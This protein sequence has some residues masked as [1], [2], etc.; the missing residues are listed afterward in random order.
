MTTLRRRG[1]PTALLCLL[2]ITPPAS[3][4]PRFDLAVNLDGFA[5]FMSSRAYIDA[6]A[7]FRRWGRAGAGWEENPALRL[8]PDN[9]PLA[10]ADAV[11]LLRGYPAGVYK[12][13][14]EGAATLTFVGFAQIVPGTL[15]T[16]GGVTTA[17]VRVAPHGG[18]DL[19]TL[20]VRGLDPAKPLRNLHLLVPGYADGTRIFTD[21]FV[22]RVRPFPTLRFMDWQQTNANPLREWSDRPRPT[23][24][25]RTGAQGVP[26]EEIVAL[27][28]VTRRNVWVNVPLHAS[29]DYVTH[30]ATLL[31]DTLH[32]AALIHVEY[33]NEVWNFG[34]EQAKDNLAA[35]KANPALTKPDDF[36]R[37]AQQAADRL[38][39]VARIFRT[40]FGDAA[41]AARVRP[42]VGGFIANTYWAQTQLDWL[43]QH[44]LGLI[45]ELAIAPYFGVEGDIKD[46]DQPGATAD[47]LFAKLNALVEGPLNTWIADHAAL[48][49]AHGVALV[50]YEGGVHLTATN[51]VNEDLKRQMQA[52]PRIADTYRHLLDVWQKHGGGLFTQFG[53]IGP[54]TKFGYWGLLESMD[55]PGS[56]K[57]DFVMSLL[58]PPG[59]ANLDGKVDFADFQIL[60]QNLGQSGRWRE[61]GD[62]NAD[63]KVD[64]A[65]LAIFRDNAHDLTPEQK[66]AFETPANGSRP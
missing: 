59:D 49:K 58:L 39:T 42:V 2:L 5:D 18:E 37:C 17:D 65:D 35:A 51:G 4:G 25:S 44:H 16:E 45:R 46:V 48:A 66:A 22:R 23:R 54:Y 14:Y 13:R 56:I 27:A 60:R 30:F 20:Q 7:L 8:S 41:Y 11:T 57:W 19:L 26:L 50:A 36:G 12:L 34:F 62:L 1:V 38:G 29:D 64:A 21:E 53:H 40:I 28:N 24:F 32:P 10:D 43:E 9:Y 47:A 15:K 52:D 3:A 63:H 31:R 61:Q 6:T 33:S 55:Q